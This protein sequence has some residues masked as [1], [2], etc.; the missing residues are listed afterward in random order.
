[1]K[2]QSLVQQ[3]CL[4]QEGVSCAFA[5]LHAIEGAALLS[6]LPRDPDAA[7]RHNHGMFLLS[8]LEDHLRSLQQKVDELAVQAA[9]QRRSGVAV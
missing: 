6:T 7:D 4:L 8:M 1:M 2:G 5:T 9:G 3:H